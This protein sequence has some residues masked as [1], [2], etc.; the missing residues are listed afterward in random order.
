MEIKQEQYTWNGTLKSRSRT[1]YI[2]IHHAA[3]P[4]CTPQDVHRWHLGNGWAGI[5]YHFFV[6]KAGTI[7]RGRPGSTIG[8]HVLG[9]NTDSIGI[10]LEGDFEKENPTTKQLDALSWLVAD[11]QKKYPGVKVVGHRDL[12]ATTC[13]GKN[14]S[15]SMLNNKGESSVEKTKVLL[16]ALGK[17]IEL[18]GII[19]NGKTYVE[20]RK[21]FE[22]EGKKVIWNPEKRMTEVRI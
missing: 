1:D 3:H 18:E 12:L 10:C 14:F 9:H 6:S 17:K 19:H 20:A 15:L 7:H 16:N 5:G 21:L 8:A 13:P 2:V 4:S 22:F 11:L